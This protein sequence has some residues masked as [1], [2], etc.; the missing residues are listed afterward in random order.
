MSQVSF[1]SPPYK[2]IVTQHTFNNEQWEDS[3]EY[4]W[5]ESGINICES[6]EIFRKFRLIHKSATQ[7]DNNQYSNSFTVS[8]PYYHRTQLLIDSFQQL[9]YFDCASIKTRQTN[10][11]IM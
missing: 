8:W 1:Q 4:E 5:Q 3:S 10:S 11:P 2:Q 6:L 7:T 9:E